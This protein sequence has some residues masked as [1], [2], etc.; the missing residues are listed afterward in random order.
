MSQ[1]TDW[2]CNQ[3]AAPAGL[4]DLSP[5]HQGHVPPPTGEGTAQCKN[6]AGV[7]E[8]PCPG[9]WGSGMLWALQAG[10][11][12]SRG[13]PSPQPSQAG[14]CQKDTFTSAQPPQKDRAEKL[15]HSDELMS[16]SGDSPG[17]LPTLWAGDQ[18]QAAVPG[19]ADG[20]TAAPAAGP[21]QAAASPQSRAQRPQ[22]A[23]LGASWVQVAGAAAR[24]A[25]I[26]L[27]W[28]RTA[29][30]VMASAGM[31]AATPEAAHTQWGSH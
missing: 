22:G 10:G 14:P 28:A 11:E 5:G 31:F 8:E 26:T 7:F 4:S 1:G 16:I 25:G 21:T 13:C 29:T 30:D 18:P 3:G 19:G 27:S 20:G 17:V 15:C 6:R 12:G 24:S 2:L 23:E 9:A